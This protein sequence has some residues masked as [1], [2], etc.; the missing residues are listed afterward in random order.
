MDP[1]ELTERLDSR[2][3]AGEQARRVVVRQARDLGDSGLITRNFGYKLTAEAVVSHL[4]DAPAEYDLVERWNWW[5][6]SLELT[7]GT[8]RRF[9]VRSDICSE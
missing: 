5:V 1:E 3:D 4:E 8:Y 7:N 9:R 2:F 6:D